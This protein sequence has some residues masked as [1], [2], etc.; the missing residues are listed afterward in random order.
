MMPP[1]LPRRL[2]EISVALAILLAATGAVRA[3]LP[4]YFPDDP[5]AR[6]PE[7]QDASRVAAWAISDPYDFIENTFFKPGD[8]GPR[9]AMNVNT[10]DEVPDSSWFTNRAGSRPL[11]A[12]EVRRS[13]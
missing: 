9:R 2:L 13:G 5:I 8:R 6:D 1:L 12:D 4:V 7:T 10:I 3:Q 11:T